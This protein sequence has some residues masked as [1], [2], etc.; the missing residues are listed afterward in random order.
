MTSR[1][2]FISHASQNG[3]LA[4]QLVDGLERNQVRCWVAPRDIRTGSDYRMALLEGISDARALLVLVTEAACK[5]RHVC[6]EVEIA[7]RHNKYVFPVRADGYEP[8]GPLYYYLVDRQWTD[9]NAGVEIALSELVEQIQSLADIGARR[10]PLPQTEAAAE[11]DNDGAVETSDVKLLSLRRSVSRLGEMPTSIRREPLLQEIAKKAKDSRL[12]VTVLQ[13]LPGSG[14]STLLCQLA[15][16]LRDGFDVFLAIDWAD[17]RSV[18]P[19][20]VLDEINQFLSALN[21]GMAPGTI[22]SFGPERALRLL[23]ERLVEFKLLLLVNAADRA[24]RGWLEQLVAAF[25]AG[26]TAKMVLT[27]DTRLLDAGTSNA[28]SVPPLSE[29]ESVE[30]IRRY[31]SDR[32]QPPTA[33]ERTDK[34]PQAVR[35]HPRSLAATLAALDELPAFLFDASGTVGDAAQGAISAVVAALDDEKK[36]TLAACAIWSGIDIGRLSAAGAIQSSPAQAQIFRVLSFQSL[37]QCATATISVPPIVRIVLCERYADFVAAA[38]ERLCAALRQ[39]IASLQSSPVQDDGFAETLAALVGGLSAMDC[40][41]SVLALVT[42]ATLDRFELGGRLKHIL[43]LLNAARAAAERVGDVRRECQLLLRIA[44]KSFQVNDGR[45]GRAAIERL[46]AVADPADTALRA[47]VLS[48]TGLMTLLEGNATLAAV[49][50]EESL[51]LRRALPGAGGLAQV[52]AV[53]AGIRQKARDFERARSF[54]REARAQ[55]RDDEPA[56]LRIM[57]QIELGLATCDEALGERDAA[58]ARVA[59]ALARAR[60]S[61]YRL[62]SAR[63]LSTM[64]RMLALQ[65]KSEDALAAAREASRLAIGHDDELSAGLAIHIW[66]LTSRPGGNLSEKKP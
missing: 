20:Y 42:D 9:F 60:A 43:L 11:L 51:V 2:L 62:G 54:Y 35:S 37:I 10:P 66:R 64:S 4:A 59:G 45:A 17:P 44:R 16:D 47:E 26:S 15:H 12:P 36:S 31:F 22:E 34:I 50:L 21:R 8:S 55:V 38:A 32:G 28:V 63:V 27:A 18:E 65:G 7:E 24:P 39:K 14:K 3:A 1:D 40:A 13:G 61:G 56:D 41:P 23:V 25:T 29:S 30:F 57:L 46:T 19:Y 48:H 52:L 6:R 53:L 33:V 49:Q 5:S 58:M